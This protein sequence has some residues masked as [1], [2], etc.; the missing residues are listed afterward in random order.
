MILGDFLYH[1]Q[2][3][4]YVFQSVYETGWNSGSWLVQGLLIL[5]GLSFLG[6][7]VGVLFPKQVQPEKQNIWRQV[8]VNVIVNCSIIFGMASFYGL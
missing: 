6:M 7:T 1:A 5:V 4:W 3:G 2:H 8:V